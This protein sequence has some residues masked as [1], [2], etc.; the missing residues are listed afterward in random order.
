V[1]S[2]EIDFDFSVSPLLFDPSAAGSGPAQVF[3]AEGRLN[4][5]FGKPVT[6][7]SRIHEWTADKAVDGDIASY[8]EGAARAW[9]G[10]IH[11]D[12]QNSAKIT[13]VVIKLN[14]ARL[15]SKRTQR[16]EV[17]V[18]DDGRNWS[19]AVP[20][21]EYTFDPAGNANTVSITLDA[22]ARYVQLVFTANS[23]AT[24]GQVAEFEVY[25]E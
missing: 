9:P 19:T 21:T 3:D 25:G 20:E 17:K 18:G 22:T 13:T 15:W 4:L 16:I 14:P 6:A 10:T 5:S 7:S 8:W 12:L 24:N 11:V 1:R 2:A 23:G